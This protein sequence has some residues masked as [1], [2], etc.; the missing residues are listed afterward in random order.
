M[1]SKTE[2]GAAGFGKGL[3]S[4][5]A[6]LVGLGGLYN[7]LG[8][9]SSDIQDSYNNMAQMSAAYTATIL[10]GVETTQ[11]D[12]QQQIAEN[13]ILADE[14]TKFLFNSVQ[15][16]VQK[17]DLFIAFVVILVFILCFYTLSMPSKT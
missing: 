15:Q 11:R 8:D 9:A 16:S 14:T 1:T 13:K 6:G 12:V 7:P 10:K 2:K 4:G 3:G 17:A 5:L